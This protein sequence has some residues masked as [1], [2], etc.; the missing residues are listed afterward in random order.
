[1]DRTYDGGLT[2][3]KDGKFARIT[4]NQGLSSDGVFCILEDDCG[5]LWMKFS[6]QGIY[7]V[8]QDGADVADGRSPFLTSIVYMKDGL[9]NVEET[10]GGSPPA[11]AR[12]MVRLVP[13]RPGH[14]HRKPGNRQ[15]QSVAAARTD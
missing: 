2:R 13:D 3:L 12:E 4:K 10:A 15:H 11:S 7:R 5:W 6:N 1:M 8:K 14:R 9:L